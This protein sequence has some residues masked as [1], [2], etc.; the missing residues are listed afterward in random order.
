MAVDRSRVRALLGRMRQGF[1]VVAAP[2]AL[3]GTVLVWK[4]LAWTLRLAMVYWFLIAF[5]L[6]SGLWIV[7]LVIAAQSLAGLLPLMPGNAGTQQAALV[8]VLAGTASGAATLGFGIGMQM[9]TSLADVAIGAA[10]AT[11]LCS[12]SDLRR[13]LWPSR[14]PVFSARP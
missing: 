5:H 8:V 7:L 14:R 1:S 13:L 10:T 9:T 3:L 4:L 2:R 12:R 11:F 6:P